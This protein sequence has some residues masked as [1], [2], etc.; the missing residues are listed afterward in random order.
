MA[1]NLLFINKHAEIIQ[2]FSREMADKN[3]EIDIAENGIDAAILL[4]QKEY[5][6]VITGLVL[7]GFNGEQIVTYINKTYPDTVCIIYTT[8]ISAAQLHFFVNERDVFRV[9]LRPVNFRKEFFEA[10]S[11]AF[12]YNELKKKN[13]EEVAVRKKKQKKNKD[14]I[15]EM[16]DFLERQINGWKPFES[17]AKKV[18]AFSIE[19]HIAKMEP[20]KRKRLKQIEYEMIAQCCNNN[21]DILKQVQ[22]DMERLF[23]KIK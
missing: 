15:L 11:E 2:E 5:Q 18:V 13:R 6:V 9:F 7:D 16:E 22:E 1:R 20:T 8:T 21:E 3:F 23:H 4:R 10:L 19:E 17:F 14:A 12:E